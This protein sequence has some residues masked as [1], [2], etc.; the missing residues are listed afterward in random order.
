VYE[1][2][3]T[4]QIDVISVSDAMKVVETISKQADAPRL[5]DLI[6]DLEKIQH[7]AVSDDCRT[8]PSRYMNKK[9]AQNKSVHGSSKHKL[10]YV[11]AVNKL[12]EQDGKVLIQCAC[13]HSKIDLQSSG[14]H[15]AHDIPQSDGGDWST[16]N[17]YL[18]CASCN[19]TMS[20]QL[21]VLE[22]KVELYVKVIE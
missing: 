22:Y 19:A 11:K 8:I 1:N 7:T 17:V 5:L 14:C 3:S 15:R 10:K 18:T 12:H 21:S 16:D 20:D 9:S 2:A 6:V 4:K 13:C